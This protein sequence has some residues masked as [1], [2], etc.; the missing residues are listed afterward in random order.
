MSRDLAQR[1]NVGGNTTTHYDFPT[2]IKFKPDRFVDFSGDNDN[3]SL[4][5]GFL[6]FVL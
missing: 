2:I 4:E 5:I 1:Y 3:I 6:S